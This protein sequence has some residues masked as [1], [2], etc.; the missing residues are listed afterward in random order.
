[1]FYKKILTKSNFNCKSKSK[2]LDNIQKPKKKKDYLEKFKYHRQKSFDLAKNVLTAHSET[3]KKILMCGK[4]SVFEK[5]TH[6]SGKKTYQQKAC[7][8][9]KKRLCQLCCWKKTIKRILFLEKNCPEITEKN[10]KLITLTLPFHR[11]FEL[12]EIRKLAQD[13]WNRFKKYPTF[14]KFFGFIR[15]V[16][17]TMGKDKDKWQAHLHLHILIEVPSDYSPYRNNFIHQKDL[18]R[19]WQGATMLGEKV[20]QV[21]IRDVDSSFAYE[22]LKYE[23]KFQDFD[24]KGLS[25]EELKKWLFAYE[26]GVKGLR[27]IVCGGSFKGA[28]KEPKDKDL[29]DNE[30]IDDKDDKIIE[31]VWIVLIHTKENKFIEKIYQREP[32]DII[33]QIQE[34]KFL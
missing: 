12:K 7:L 4:I 18:L 34:K 19:D 33:E 23:L 24:R 3:G 29:L 17:I 16:E 22:L 13:S 14:K 9:C 28:I 6:E 10:L 31:T 30:K 32:K 11:V 2:K 8:F 25:T 26:Y 1:M 27:N 5:N 21:N 20:K 15:V